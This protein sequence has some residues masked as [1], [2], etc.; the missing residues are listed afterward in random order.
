M[1]NLKGSKMYS[2]KTEN[3]RSA[4]VARVQ[5]AI[6]DAGVKIG[7]RVVTSRDPEFVKLRRSLTVDKTAEVTQ[8]QLPFSIGPDNGAQA[9][10]GA[11]LFVLMSQPGAQIDA[12]S[13]REGVSF[14]FVG[15]G[16]VAV[17]GKELSSGDWWYVPTGKSY[18]FEAGPQGAVTLGCHYCCCG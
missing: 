3:T 13:H 18:A 1:F 11:Q 15:S 2:P 14:H 4:C 8:W 9:T 10:E 6:A 16:S 17:E 5:K 12:H 7:D